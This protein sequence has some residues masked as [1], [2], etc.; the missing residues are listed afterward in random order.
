MN[1][2]P[3]PVPAPPPKDEGTILAGFLLAWVAGI[4]G[5][6]AAVLIGA[7]LSLAASP[8]IVPLLVVAGLLPL[9]AP[10][11]LAVWFARQGRTRAV[12]G[13]LYALLTMIVLLV[14]FVGALFLLFSH[15]DF[16]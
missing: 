13:A 7:L 5:T 1:A 2:I 15:A 4:A 11:G 12:R 10:I 3:N 6:L 8:E 16:R 9:A 14:L